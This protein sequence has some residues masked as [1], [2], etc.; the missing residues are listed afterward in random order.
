MQ[1]ERWVGGGRE[2]EGP[3]GGAVNATGSR[4]QAVWYF[5]KLPLKESEPGACWEVWTRAYRVGRRT[6]PN[7]L[8]G[9]FG[10]RMR[11]AR[12]RMVLGSLPVC[13]G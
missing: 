6:D 11:D 13:P 3:G 8:T 10:G 5:M 1:R 4:S 12:S 2:M 7:A 9:D